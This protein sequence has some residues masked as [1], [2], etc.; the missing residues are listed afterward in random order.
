MIRPARVLHARLDLLDRQLLD[1]DGNG[2]GNVDDVELTVDT[3]GSLWVTGLLTGPGQ[4]V[5][6]LGGR[7]L[8]RWLETADR[9]VVGP[10][11]EDRCR[12][13]IE[14]AYSVG[15][16]VR[17]AK[18]SDELASNDLERWVRDHIIGKIPGARHAPAPE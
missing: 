6:R 11:D 17:V 10:G 12:V 3:D 1:R 18:P 4:L 8:G 16:A 13:P 7:R 5:Y 15:A 14:L 9:K 2:C